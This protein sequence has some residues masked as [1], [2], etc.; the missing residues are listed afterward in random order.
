MILKYQSN[1]Y[2][3]GIGLFGWWIL[4]SLPLLNNLVPIDSNWILLCT[5]KGVQLV[6]VAQSS[7]SHSTHEVSHCPCLS[8]VSTSKDARYHVTSQQQ[9]FLAAPIYVFYPSNPSH[10]QK[11][12]RA[13]P[14]S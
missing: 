1:I 11:I 13:P 8:E 7:E 2:L 12:P 5:Q 10:L 6:N 9:V 14:I 4:F 3:K